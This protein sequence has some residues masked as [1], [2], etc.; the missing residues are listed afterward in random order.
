MY[1]MCANISYLQVS[2]AISCAICITN[3]NNWIQK[4]FQETSPKKEKEAM[5]SFIK[6][7]KDSSSFDALGNILKA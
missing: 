4:C 7:G 2:S 1:N 6:F 3:M 5:K